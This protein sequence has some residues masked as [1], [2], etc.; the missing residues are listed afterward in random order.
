MAKATWQGY[1]ALG[2]LGIP[3]RLHSATQSLRPRFVQ[4]HEKDGSP[5]ERELRCKHEKREIAPSEIIRAVE[6]EPGKY[7]TLTD[8]ELE[9]SATSPIKTIDVKQFCDPE[10]IDPIYFEKPYYIAPTRGGE[11]A[12]SLLREVLARTGKIA[13]VQ[14][15]IY[16]KERIAAIGIHGDLLV[17]QQLRFDTEIVPRSSIK[18]PALPKPSPAE[19]EAL[20][21]VVER[22]TSPL[23]IQDYHD[24]HAEHIN[25]L[26]ERKAK[27]L[28]APRAE[29]TAPNATPE[30]EIVNALEDTLGD[31]PAL[32][33]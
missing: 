20:S 31:Q 15:V 16:N 28:P 10:A 8:R 22:Y 9:Q 3:V 13:I 26:I 7:I 6:Y 18:T 32:R 21:T 4:L 5:V 27:G 29:R 19:I 25:E 12:Y 30:S 17:L 1:I 23:Y 2:K 14:F 33:A 11:R 24:E